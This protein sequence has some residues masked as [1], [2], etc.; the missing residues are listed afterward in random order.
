MRSSLPA[1][2]RSRLRGQHPTRLP[3]SRNLPIPAS[4]LARRPLAAMSCPD[5]HATL[6][7]VYGPAKARQAMSTPQLT[8]DEAHP[9][10]GA[11]R[12]GAPAG[13]LVADRYRLMGLLGRGGMG[14][15]WLAEDEV[16]RRSVAL[17]QILVNGLHSAKHRAEA[18]ECAVREARAAARVDHVAVLATERG[19]RMSYELTPD[20]PPPPADP[21]PRPRRSPGRTR[22]PA[23]TARPRPTRRDPRPPPKAPHAALTTGHPRP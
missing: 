11:P 7:S 16:P 9:T 21:R 4:L 22:N 20:H 3:A 5:G 17:K 23:P 19:V 2:A 10:A 1:M 18:W 12:A 13:R 8:I 15:V 6:I 14:R